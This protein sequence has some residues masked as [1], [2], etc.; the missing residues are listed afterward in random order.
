MA[1]IVE[2]AVIEPGEHFSL[3]GH[4]GRRT[5]ARGFV[6]APVIVEGEFE[7]EV[8]GGVSQFATTF[9]DAAYFSGI[10]ID[11][12]QQHSY[13][14]SRYPM[15][16]ESTIY[17][18]LIDVAVTNDS[19]YGILVHTS[20]TAHLHHRGVLQHALGRGGQRNDRAL[21]RRAGPGPQRVRRHRHEDDHLPRRGAADRG[22]LPPLPAAGLRRLV[23]TGVNVA[24]SRLGLRH[25]GPVH[26]KRPHP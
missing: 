12:F 16:R 18:G 14:I 2:G 11:E 4:M 3:N 25:P 15:G 8:G 20:Y 10:Q 13:Y 19:P 1:D 24:P 17:Y 22:V 23:L 7:E 9:F 6:A 5:R 26:L 21:Q